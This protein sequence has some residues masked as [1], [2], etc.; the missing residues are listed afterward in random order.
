M[1]TH[2]EGEKLKKVD[3]K[4][5][6]HNALFDS[7]RQNISWSSSA[8]DHRHVSFALQRDTRLAKLPY[9]YVSLADFT[10]V[11]REDIIYSEVSALLLLQH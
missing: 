4:Y 8:F 6:I 5:F 7:R 1:G 11:E 9:M 10:Q 2:N 3:I